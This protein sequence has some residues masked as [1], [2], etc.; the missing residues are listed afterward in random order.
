MRI[1]FTA[2]G[3]YL[4]AAIS[5]MWLDLPGFTLPFWPAAGF[6]LAM[7]LIWGRSAV[8]GIVIAAFLGDTFLVDKADNLLF[9]LDAWMWPLFTAASAGLQA[10]IGWRLIVKVTR[11]PW[12]L[13]I[14]RQILAITLLGGV[15]ACLVSSSISLL[16]SWLHADAEA[17]LLPWFSGFIDDSIGVLLVT[18]LVLLLERALVSGQWWRKVQVTSAVVVALVVALVAAMQLNSSEQ[19]ALESRIEY[20]SETLRG[21]LGERLGVLE[22]SLY[23]LAAFFR[24]SDSVNESEFN[25]FAAVVAPRY[26]ESRMIA[27]LPRVAAGQREIFEATEGAQVMGDYRIHSRGSDSAYPA[28]RTMHFPVLYQVTA[29][30][31]EMKPGLDLYAW[32]Q[33]R[34]AIDKAMTT[35]GLSISDVVQSHEFGVG[36]PVVFLYKSVSDSQGKVAGMIALMIDLQSII[37]PLLARTKNTDLHIVVREYGSELP[38]VNIHHGEDTG[39]QLDDVLPML[40]ENELDYA[41]ADR[42]WKVHLFFSTETRFHGTSFEIWLFLVFSML[43]TGVIGM[44][45]LLITGQNQAVKRQVMERTAQLEAANRKMEMLSGSDPLTGVLNRRRFNEMFVERINEAIQNNEPMLVAMLDVD[46]FRKVNDTQGRRYGDTVLLLV[47]NSLT[48]Q[49]ADSQNLIARFGGDEFMV[50]ISGRDPEEVESRFRQVR[51]RVQD[52]ARQDF[53][54]GEE[55]ELFSL[56]VGIVIVPR[57]QSGMTY[58]VLVDEADKALYLAKSSGGNHS[59]RSVL[60]AV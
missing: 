50:V 46:N 53:R 8:W 4:L 33:Q 25:Q 35:G 18:P 51:E 7:T 47:A 21:V 57:M 11:P 43:F 10:W 1:L 49:F 60:S 13:D 15:V 44:I 6:A 32:P 24:N 3:Y 26:G 36:Q 48:E 2:A 29:N 5:Q 40:V 17:S 38:V 39:G 28:D 23:S 41:F 30:S 12:R 16:S 9:S 14:P 42:V 56:S 58:E 54:E 27:W 59:A 45:A 20:E 22:Q 55:D 52:Y 34:K 37:Q 19:R 31:P